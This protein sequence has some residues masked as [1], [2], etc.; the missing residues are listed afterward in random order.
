MK[1]TNISSIYPHA[2]HGSNNNI[3]LD[4]DDDMG[5]PLKSRI[6]GKNNMPMIKPKISVEKTPK[7]NGKNKKS[8]PTVLPMPSFTE[9]PTQ[10]CTVEHTKKRVMAPSSMNSNLP[11]VNEGNHA[12]EKPNAR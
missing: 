9:Q 2:K 8:I 1:Q 6:N 3:N 5:S 7:S 12:E 4:D 10:A 11:L